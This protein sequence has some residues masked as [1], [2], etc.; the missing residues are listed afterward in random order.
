MIERRLTEEIENRFHFSLGKLKSNLFKW[1]LLIPLTGMR[2]TIFNLSEW[3]KGASC[4]TFRTELFDKPRLIILRNN[5]IG[6]SIRKSPEGTTVPVMGLF[7]LHK[8]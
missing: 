3:S 7:I 6:E 8:L 5:A 2:Y 1:T 4:A